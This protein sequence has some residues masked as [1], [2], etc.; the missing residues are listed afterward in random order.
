[1]GG[2]TR[3]P[4]A[5]EF[6]QQVMESYATGRRIADL[7]REFGVFEHWISRWIIRA[8]QLVQLP[9]RGRAVARADNHAPAVASIL[10]A[11]AM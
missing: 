3:P 2:K 10:A 8:R 9:D 11:A 5:P 4:Y 7:A 6:L 1:M